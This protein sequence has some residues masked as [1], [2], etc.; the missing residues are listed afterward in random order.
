[1]PQITKT[2][3]ELVDEARTRIIEIET[4]DALNLVDSDDV[5]LIDIRE[6]GEREK[7]GMLPG[8]IHCARAF[9]EFAVDPS[10]PL[11]KPEFAQDKQ[12][13]VYC[14]SGMRSALAVASLQAMGFDA[15]HLKEGFGGYL[16]QGGKVEPVE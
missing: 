12:M 7:S 1:M 6:A 14:A 15:V 4:T 11:H 3:K 10:S 5:V 16:K 8:S 9:L 2:A 13:V